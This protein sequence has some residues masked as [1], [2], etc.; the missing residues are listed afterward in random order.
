MNNNHAKIDV[1]HS[2]LMGKNVLVL[3]SHD[4]YSGVLLRVSPF[5]EF[6]LPVYDIVD[7]RSEITSVV[8]IIVPRI[9]KIIKCIESLKKLDFNLLRQITAPYIFEPYTFETFFDKTA[10]QRV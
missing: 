3:S 6:N 7:S 5:S 2:E 10:Y 9:P 8:G 1:H 4:F